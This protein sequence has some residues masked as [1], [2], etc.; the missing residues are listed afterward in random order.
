MEYERKLKAGFFPGAKDIL[1]QT[2]C[3]NQL[4]LSNSFAETAQ[5]AGSSEKVLRKNYANR[6]LE[7][8]ADKFFGNCRQ[9]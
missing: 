3:S 9:A 6:T 5:E 2:F 4:V 8:K 7:A 1:R